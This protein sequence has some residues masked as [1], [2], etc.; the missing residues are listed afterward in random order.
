MK[1][2]NI[3]MLIF[4]TLIVMLVFGS[5]DC[6]PDPPFGF[7]PPTVEGNY[8]GWYQYIIINTNDTLIQTIN[9]QFT[10]TEYEMKVDTESVDYS[11]FCLCETK[12]QY[13][14]EDRV[15]L[16]EISYNSLISECVNCDTTR[17]PTGQFLLDRSTDTLV[18]TQQIT[19]EGVTI[20]KKIILIELLSH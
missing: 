10:D 20:I 13:L 4:V 3:F 5:C 9:W 8:I 1:L 18:M 12:G 6:D 16:K 14:L 19:D 7:Y 11:D 17:N 15:R 2:Q